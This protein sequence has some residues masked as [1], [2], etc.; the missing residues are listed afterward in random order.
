MP[1]RKPGRASSSEE[2]PQMPL[3]VIRHGGEPL[4]IPAGGEYRIPHHQGDVPHAEES[5][6]LQFV[7]TRSGHSVPVHVPT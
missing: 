4:G 6:I 7:R 2:F 3:Q 5:L 1:R